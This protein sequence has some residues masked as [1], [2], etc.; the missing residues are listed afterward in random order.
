MDAS[1]LAADG[2]LPEDVPALQALLR[3]ALVEAAAAT[4]FDAGVANRI[5]SVTRRYGLDALT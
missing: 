5:H 2:H 1:S 3:Q 4:P